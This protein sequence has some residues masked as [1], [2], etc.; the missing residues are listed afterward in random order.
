MRKM[1]LQEMTIFA[2]IARLTSFSVVSA[3]TQK[4]GVVCGSLIP[5]DAYKYLDFGGR[6]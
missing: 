5:L 6:I 3:G 2:E 1:S 4:Q